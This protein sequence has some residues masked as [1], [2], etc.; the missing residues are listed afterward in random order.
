MQIIFIKLKY[1][2]ILSDRKALSVFVSLNFKLNSMAFAKK[3]DLKVF[4]NV[5]TLENGPS[6][7]NFDLKSDF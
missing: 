6:F 1:L 3:S 2:F 5:M 7:S 4:S